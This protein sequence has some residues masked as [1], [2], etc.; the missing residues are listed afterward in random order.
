MRLT[1]H[2]GLGNDFV[3][4][5]DPTDQCRVGPE[6]VRAICDRHRGIGAD[7]FLR[8]VPSST[9]PAHDHDTTDLAMHLHNA[10]GSRATMSGNGIGCLVQ[11]AVLA[12]VVP[13]GTVRVSTDAG[14]RTVAVDAG[15]G[16]RSHRVTVDMGAAKV[17]EEEP[18]WVT[19]AIRRAVLV[20]VGN[21]HL[22]LHIDANDRSGGIDALD[23]FDLADLGACVNE[24]V[25]GGINVEL[26]APEVT[27]AVDE[28][29][30]RVYERGVG[31]TEACGTGACA[32]AA[33]ARH[34]NLVGDRVRVHQPGGMADVMQDA[35]VHL[36]I[37][38]EYVA[39][40][41]WPDA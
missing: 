4:L 39:S 2:H 28:L 23:A 37:P 20:D 22:V 11:A 8:A 36:T 30:M 12:G 13:T 34:W 10:D 27:G 41:E 31:L 17:G 29:R 21:P 16:R 33:A 18:R 32:A 7:G 9:A 26:V 6:L 3:V 1:K 25:P 5:V 14:L 24:Q 40:I 38:V 15:P 35:T 19:G